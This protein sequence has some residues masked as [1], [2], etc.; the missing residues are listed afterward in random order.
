VHTLEASSLAELEHTVAAMCLRHAWF[1]AEEAEIAAREFVKDRATTVTHAGPQKFGY[2]LGRH[3]IR[4]DDVRLLDWALT[5]ASAVIAAAAVSGQ[6][7]A[8]TISA[9]VLAAVRLGANVWSSGARLNELQFRVFTVL[10]LNTSIPN[11]N[12]LTLEQLVEVLRRNDT[13][14]DSDVVARVLS[15]L[16][17]YQVRNMLERQFVTQN[18]AGVWRSLV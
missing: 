11:Q 3:I 12:G 15:S 10:R 4:S 7:S 9:L 2:V 14:I 1:T 17:Q 18:A 16:K 5:S 13:T 8:L 6:N